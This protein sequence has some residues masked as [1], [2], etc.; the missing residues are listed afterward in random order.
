MTRPWPVTENEFLL[1]DA[2]Y[3]AMRYFDL[4]ADSAEYASIEKF[5]ANAIMDE[6]ARPS[7]AVHIGAC[8][9]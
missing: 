3:I 8:R 1:D 2:L 4:P 6:T 7:P 9:G 5:A